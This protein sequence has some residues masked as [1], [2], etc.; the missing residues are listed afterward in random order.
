M[1]PLTQDFPARAATAVRPKRPSAK[2]SGDPKLK[3]M[4]ASGTAVRIKA[5][6][7]K[8][9]HKAIPI[10]ALNPGKAPTR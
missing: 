9:K 8:G 6:V 3:A 2:Y 4:L 7:V 10:V 5:I 1:H